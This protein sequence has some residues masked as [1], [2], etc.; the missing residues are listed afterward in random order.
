FKGVPWYFYFVFI[1]VKLPV[2][3]I[4]AFLVG[5]P[6][7][8]RR[9]LG[10]GRYFL[11]FWTVIGFAPF[12]F[13]GGKFTRYFTPELPV[14]FITA[15]IGV[16]FI[17]RQIARASANDHLKPYVVTALAL[18]VVFSSVWA[19]ASAA[20]YYRLYTNALGGGEERPGSAHR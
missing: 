3:T 11:L 5:L 2:A 19:S 16:Q 20:P 9:K 12:V 18:L 4:A 1:A 15:A 14:V 10:D 7:L 17:G 13:V 6:L 8:F